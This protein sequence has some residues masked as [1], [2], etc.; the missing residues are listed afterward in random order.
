MAGTPHLR[1]RIDSSED[2]VDDAMV[3]ILAGVNA[4]SVRRPAREMLECSYAVRPETGRLTG[5]GK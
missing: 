3:R 1:R 2:G 5:D 4:G